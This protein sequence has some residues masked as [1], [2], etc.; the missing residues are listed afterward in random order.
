MNMEDSHLSLISA[1]KDKPIPKD[2]MAVGEI[3]LSGEVSMVTNREQ[4]KRSRKIR[5]YKGKSQ[6]IY[7]T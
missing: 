7:I 6:K 1:F 4:I 2:L 3:G 5:I